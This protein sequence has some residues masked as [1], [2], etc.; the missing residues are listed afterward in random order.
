MSKI[1]TDISKVDLS[2]SAL[3]IFFPNGDTIT[4]NKLNDLTVH[5]EYLYV[6]STVSNQISKL[7]EEIDIDYYL[8]NPAKLYSDIMVL[9]AINNCAVYLNVQ[10]GI[11][12]PTNDAMIF[13]PEQISTEMKNNFNKNVNKF[14]STVFYDI[15]QFNST[16]GNFESRG[17]FTGEPN[18]N[19]FMDV[20]NE[21]CEM[22]KPTR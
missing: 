2:T 20:I 11:S 22:I 14:L 12:K 17:C 18:G 6:L 15:C 4:I 8:K 10:I 7:L 13:L 3:T 1:I 19:L 16:T 9:F 21:N 5:M